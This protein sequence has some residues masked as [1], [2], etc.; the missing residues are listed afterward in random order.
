MKTIVCLNEKN[1][2]MN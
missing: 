2:M 1:L